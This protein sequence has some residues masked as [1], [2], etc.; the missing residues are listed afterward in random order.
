VGGLERIVRVLKRNNR[1]KLF[2]FPIQP[3]AQE[4]NRYAKARVEMLSWRL[5]NPRR[6]QCPRCVKCCG[7]CVSIFNCKL[8]TFKTSEGLMRYWVMC[9]RQMFVL[10]PLTGQS[11]I[12]VINGMIMDLYSTNLCSP[13][14]HTGCFFLSLDGKQWGEPQGPR[15]HSQYSQHDPGCNG[16]HQTPVYMLE[17]SLTRAQTKYVR[18]TLRCTL[19]CA[20]ISS[21]CI[22]SQNTP[23]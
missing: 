8:W 15:Q 22:L 7:R 2:C 4:T 10:K 19:L 17:P 9:V 13:C 23:P 18:P 14:R 21:G 12:C 16:M 20:P 6:A 1:K 3:H 5:H 11:K